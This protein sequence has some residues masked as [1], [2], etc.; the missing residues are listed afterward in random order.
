MSQPWRRGFSLSI[1]VLRR[2]KVRPSG[3]VSR[4]LVSVAKY[5]IFGGSRFR[6]LQSKKDGVTYYVWSRN[7]LFGSSANTLNGRQISPHR[8]FIQFLGFLLIEHV[9]LWKN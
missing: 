1:P 5:L 2:C 3:G 4:S 6:N 7:S 8:P 9:G